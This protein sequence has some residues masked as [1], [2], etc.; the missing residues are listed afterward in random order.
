MFDLGPYFFLFGLYF[1]NYT[2]H[3]L[4][5]A[6]RQEFFSVIRAPSQVLSVN[7]PLTHINYLGDI[8]Q[9]HAHLLHNRIVSEFF[10]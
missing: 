3:L 1:P 2:G 10:V 9:L 8:F 5:R 6:F 7:A 4:H